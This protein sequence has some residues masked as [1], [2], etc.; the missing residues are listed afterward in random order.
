MWYNSQVIMINVKKIFSIA[1][2]IRGAFRGYKRRLV[3]LTF[4]GFAS[5]FFAS[6]GIGAAIP[7]FSLATG[8]TVPGADIPTRIVTGTLQF[9]HLPVNAA[10]LMGLIVVLFCGKALAQFFAKYNSDKI[11]ARYIF[12]KQKKLFGQTMRSSWPYLLNLKIGHMER[13]VLYDVLVGAEILGQISSIILILTSFIMYASVA[14]SISA[15]ITLLTITFGAIIFFLTKPIFYRTRKLYENISVMQK[16]VSHYIGESTIGAKLI[17][18]TGAEEKVSLIGSRLFDQL[19]HQKIL[20]AF[21]NYLITAFFEPAG[22]IFIAIL[23]LVSYRSPGFNIAAFAVVIYLVQKMFSFTQSIQGQIQNINT[24]VP[25]LRSV[26]KYQ[27]LADKNQEITHGTAPFVFSKKILFE[28]VA[29][30]YEEKPGLLSE[31]SFEI[32][33]GDILGI[34][35]PSGSG[36]TT[37]VDLF[38]RLFEPTGGTIQVDG[39]DIRSIELEQWRKHI[40]YVPQET[41]LL[42][43]TLEQNIRFYDDQISN[44]A[45]QEAVKSAQLEDVVANLPEGLKTI[46]GERGVKLSGGQRQR[47]AL[48]RALARKPDILVLDEA[49]SSLD[50]AS[51]TLIQNAIHN[52]RGNIT[53]IIIAHRLST[54]MKADHVVVL[55]QGS[56]TKQGIPEDIVDGRHIKN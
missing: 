12:D 21:Y 10:F 3:L 11:A 26:I 24:S 55:D 5:G 30:G 34:I 4:L 46:V 52:L 27:E 42:N 48:A 51:E 33:K 20:G 13:T 7:L 23:F 18:I 37:L 16:D 56:I 22:Y 32:K 54:I 53:I 31:I 35:G 14:I 47:I 43:D 2:L 6:V 38:L 25:Y 36:K 17:K 44:S 29:F 40:G 19:K 39:T 15:K 45:I 41:F 9:A 8:Q 28:N 50:N 49:T 1:N